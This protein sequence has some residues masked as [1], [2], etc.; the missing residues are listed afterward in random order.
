M[1]IFMHIYLAV[2]CYP[3]I[4]PLLFLADLEDKYRNWEVPEEMR[5]FVA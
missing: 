1:N 5:A 2:I 4:V 3:V